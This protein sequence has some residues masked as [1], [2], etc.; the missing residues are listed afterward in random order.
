MPKKCILFSFWTLCIFF[1]IEI[2][3]YFFVIQRKHLLLR[4]IISE[5]KNDL[6]FVFQ[7]WNNCFSLSYLTAI[8][9]FMYSDVITVKITYCHLLQAI[10]H[11]F[12]L[13]FFCFNRIAYVKKWFDFVFWWGAIW[14]KFLIFMNK[15]TELIDHF[16][17]KSF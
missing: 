9:N 8:F 14:I 1:L 2:E 15:N 13:R 4:A 16:K 11:L 7:F 12:C 10:L 17:R 6:C 5:A 3:H